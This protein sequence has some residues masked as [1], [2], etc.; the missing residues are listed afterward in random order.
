MAQGSNK[1]FYRLNLAHKG[2]NITCTGWL[3]GCSYS[4]KSL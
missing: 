2:N 4:F 1:I 3:Y